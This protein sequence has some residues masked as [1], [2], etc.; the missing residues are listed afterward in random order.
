MKNQT[1]TMPAADELLAILRANDRLQAGRDLSGVL[2]HMALLEKQLA[3]VTEELHGVQAELAKM[4][5]PG[6]VMAAWQKLSDS[7][8]ERM[9][10]IRSQLAAVRD[11]IAQG[12]RDAVAAVKRSGIAALDGAL[13]FAGA[14]ETL[15]AIGAGLD[16]AAKDAAATSKKVAAISA[17]YHEAGKH[18]RN[19]GRAIRGKEPLAQRKPDGVLSRGTQSIFGGIRD[20]LA[21][22]AGDADRAVACLARLEQA[23]AKVKESRGSLKN[24]LQTYQAGLPPPKAPEQARQEKAL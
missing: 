16:S 8:R 10:A 22:M 17:E 9:A 2:G 23:A 14:K 12:A 24:R 3:A 5:E 19:F 6:P 18:L 7:L 21:G 4:Q 15:Q 13:R 20:V 11:Y 1:T